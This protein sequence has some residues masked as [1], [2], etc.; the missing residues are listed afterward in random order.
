L[1]TGSTDTAP[2]GMQMTVSVPPAVAFI[3]AWSWAPPLWWR[4]LM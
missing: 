1:P 4:L 3:P 2:V